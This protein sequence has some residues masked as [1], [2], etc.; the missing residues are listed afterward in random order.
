LRAYRAFFL[1]SVDAHSGVD[2]RDHR[3]LC[4][5]GGVTS[6]PTLRFYSARNRSS[7]VPYEESDDFVEVHT[8]QLAV[9]SPLSRLVELDLAS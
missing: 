8:P 5:S 1:G 2:C 9:A 6:L 7:A 4:N 3:G